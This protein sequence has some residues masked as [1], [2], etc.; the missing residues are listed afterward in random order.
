[1]RT[2]LCTVIASF[3]GPLAVVASC[4]VDDLDVT[5]K[6]C[7]CISGYVC[8]V[9][10]NTCVLG[11]RP[12]AAFPTSAPRPTRSSHRSAIHRRSSDVIRARSRLATPNVVRWELKV[13][14]KAT[15]CKSYAVEVVATRR[16]RSY[17]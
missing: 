9:P 5:G 2:R 11:L 8:D 13:E 1:M 7:P 16:G 15:D 3:A 6:K 4:A 17:G 14:G 10:S 12:K